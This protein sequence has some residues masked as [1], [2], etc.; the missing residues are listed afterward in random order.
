MKAVAPPSVDEYMKALPGDVF[1]VLDKI[2]SQI[3]SAAPKAEEVISYQMPAYKHHGMLVYFAAFKDHC[4]LF[5]A[6]KKVLGVFK[7]D[8]KNF[9]TFG[10]TIQ[11]TLDHPLPLK[12]VKQIVQYRVKENEEKKALKDAH[13]KAPR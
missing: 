6:S 11:F 4:S 7:N 2:R 5:P 1:K 10:G 13:K 3:K 9:K 12:L 8:L